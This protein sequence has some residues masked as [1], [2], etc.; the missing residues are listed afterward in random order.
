MN[1]FSLA[2]TDVETSVRFYRDFLGFEEIK[3]PSQFDFDGSW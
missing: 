3:R 1:H 2:V